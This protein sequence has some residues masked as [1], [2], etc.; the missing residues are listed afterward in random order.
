M[1]ICTHVPY[2]SCSAQGCTVSRNRAISMGEWAFSTRI[3][4]GYIFIQTLQQR[5]R[6]GERVVPDRNY[7]DEFYISTSTGH[8][9]YAR[10]QK[11]ICAGPETA[12]GRFQLFSMLRHI[13]CVLAHMLFLH[14]MLDYNN[15]VGFNQ[16]IVFILLNILP[17]LMKF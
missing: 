10:L 17:E 8:Q 16:S 3:T 7:Y 5:M 15:H 6:L 2:A 11:C 12:N 4:L 9:I 1:G 14:F 13:F